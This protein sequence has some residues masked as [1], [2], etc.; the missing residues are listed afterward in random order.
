MQ[1]IKTKKCELEEFLNDKNYD[2]CL[3]EHFITDGEILCLTFDNCK[4]CSY[5]PRQYYIYGRILI[6]RILN[7][8]GRYGLVRTE[9]Y[10]LTLS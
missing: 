5:F 9:R 2:L 1:S 4:L 8:T 6:L 7:S 10:K 3:R